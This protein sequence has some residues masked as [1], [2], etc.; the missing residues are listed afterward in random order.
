MYSTKFKINVTKEIYESAKNCKS[1][2]P[3]SK[4]N[5]IGSNCAIA[6]AVA[7]LFPDVWVETQKID[8][9]SDWHEYIEGP[10]AYV[11]KYGSVELPI[12]VQDMI[13]LFDNTSV[14]D[15]PNLPEFSFE[16]EVPDTLLEKVVDISSI[17]EILKDCKSLE[18][19]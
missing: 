18:L 8:F 13:I 3:I 19:V 2:L 9:V 1:I 10:S 15:R 4:G 14:E 11:G 6:K 12:E 17:E 5:G 7:V 16:I